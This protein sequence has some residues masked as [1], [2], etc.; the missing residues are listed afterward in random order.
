MREAVRICGLGTRIPEE[1]TLEALIALGECREVYCAVE[2]KRSFAWLKSHGLKLKRP[3]GAAEIVA[4]AKK[5]GDPVGLAVWGHP[6]FTS[7]LARDVERGLRAAGIE[8]K[9][10]GAISPVGS[11]FARSVSFLGGD[12]GYQG[13]QCYDVET[14]LAEPS[15]A[16]DR[17]PLIV[18]AEKASPAKWKELFSLL[19]TRYPSSHEARIYPVGSDEERKVAVGKLNAKGLTGATILV[20]PKGGAPKRPHDIA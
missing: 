8:Y 15:A 16:T 20:P 12:Y 2:N 17:L 1:T 14:L 18:C 19:G 11:A 3:K 5:Q 9:V 6:Q 13:L 4:A 10:Y 7:R